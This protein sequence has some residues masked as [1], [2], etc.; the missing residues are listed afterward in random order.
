MQDEP[1]DI[2]ND[3]KHLERELK[4]EELRNLRAGR[5]FMWLNPAALG[6]MLPIVGAAG[7]F[8]INEIRGYNEAYRAIGQLEQSR[9]EATS[10][11]QQKNDLNQEIVALLALKDHFS[12]EAKRME[13][14][15]E[16]QQMIAD[17]LY[18]RAKFAAHE[19]QYAMDHATEIGDRISPQDF[20]AALESAGPLPLN[21]QETLSE[22]NERYQIFADMAD[23]SD[24][25]LS[26]LLKTLNDFGPSDEARKLEWNPTG[27]FDAGQKI[28]TYQNDP[29]TPY[30]NV[31]LG[32]FLT[33]TEIEAFNG[34]FRQIS[35]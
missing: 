32:R 26:E 27:M 13:I 30:Y 29:N 21:A 33:K 16:D 12:N 34:P 25:T 14:L 9:A 10:L 6:V 24:E 8:I 28:M 7:L 23:V 15:L 5:K 18:L 22:L 3:I 4:R 31:D 11:Q 1:A 20:R 2:E 35:D 19:T 17:Q